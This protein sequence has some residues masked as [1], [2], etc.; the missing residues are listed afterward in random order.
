MTDHGRKYPTWSAQP[1]EPRLL[2]AGAL[3]CSFSLAVSRPFHH[4]NTTWLSG[5]DRA[6]SR[7]MNHNIPGPDPADYIHVWSEMGVPRSKAISVPRLLSFSAVISVVINVRYRQRSHP[8]SA[9]IPHA[10][11]RFN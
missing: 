1:S 9:H 6:E 3:P 11:Y 2:S 10:P 7:L 5:P 8:D 4:G